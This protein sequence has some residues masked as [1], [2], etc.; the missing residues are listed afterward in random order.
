MPIAVISASTVK[1]P[2]SITTR[3][4][5]RAHANGRPAV[6]EPDDH[7]A[8]GQSAGARLARYATAPSKAA[9]W[10]AL[11]G[12]G[13]DALAYAEKRGNKWR[14]RWRGPSGVLEQ[15][16][17][18][19]SQKAA[20]TYARDQEAAIRTNTYVDPRAG[21][22]TLTD[23]VN[24]WYPA[25][26]LEPTTLA[27]YRYAIEV[28]ILPEFG[29]RQLRSI[30]AEEVAAWEMRIAASGYSRRTARDARTTLTTIFGDAIPRHVQVNPAQRRR[31]KGRKGQRRIERIEH[32]EKVWPTPLQALLVAE[33]CA[34]LSGRD[35]EFV[36]VITLAYTGMRWGELLA[37]TPKA[38]CG[39]QLR[40]DWKLYELGGRFY[41]GRPKDGSMR[42]VDL[43]PFLAELLANY[44]RDNPPQT[45]K[46]R[47][48]DKPWCSG[49][50][51]VFLTPAL[52]HPARSDF[53]ERRF[54]PA[55]DGRYP[56]RG[57]RPAMPVLIDASTPCPGTLLAP[58]PSAEPGVPFEPPTGRGVTRLV[59]DDL[60]GRCQSCSRALPRRADGLIIAHKSA[61]FRC[62]GS[63]QPPGDDIAVA[64]WLPISRDL[65]PHGLRHG[66]KVWMDEDGIAHV[67]KA[68]RL[69][70]EESGMRSVYGHVSPLMRAEL[71]VALED[72][73]SYASRDRARQSGLPGV[74]TP[75]ALLGELRSGTLQ[76]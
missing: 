8:E 24:Q 49:A 64:S 12:L 73:W 61:G 18:F 54:R 43:P 34:A 55:A 30:T 63:S 14:A 60:T 16:G 74:V 44:F 11:S 31:G 15:Q 58:W 26:D 22:I 71:K 40:I 56:A 23:W 38:I 1:N 46:C 3:A 70:H 29:D 9:A 48:R 2:G 33:R 25:Q 6:G 62:I 20:L 52:S 69:G 41:K 27:N 57:T 45:C 65:T 36:M 47:N 21:Q 28:H 76:G 68:D 50:E 19:D 37:L 53:G 72:R 5:Q 39:D 4:H 42:V 75:R 66:H 13:D 10:S 17:G 32:A 59:S 35:T 7:Q 51:Y 67:L